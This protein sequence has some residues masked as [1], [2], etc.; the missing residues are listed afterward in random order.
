MTELTLFVLALAVPLFAMA[1]ALR[2]YNMLKG[3][4]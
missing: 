1:F 2:E 4:R 3:R